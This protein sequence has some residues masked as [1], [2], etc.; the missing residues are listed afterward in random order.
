M[1]RPGRR[2]GPEK[3]KRASDAL[4]ILIEMSKVRSQYQQEAILLKR[5]MMKAAGK[6][7]FEVGHLR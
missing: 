1:R 5:E 7:E 4:Q 2:T 3:A 6:S